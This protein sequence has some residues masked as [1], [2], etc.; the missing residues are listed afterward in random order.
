MI[1]SIAVLNDAFR[2]TFRGGHVMM[3]I[4][5]AELPE[6]VKAEALRHVADFSGF[7][8]END[9]YGEHDFG[10]FDLVGRKFFWKIDYYDEDMRFGSED[11][12]DPKRT[13]RVLTLMLSSEY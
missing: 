10:S 4:E 11:P 12:S 5:V 13:V 3:T 2:R 7:T 9:P 6:C 8:E 1:N